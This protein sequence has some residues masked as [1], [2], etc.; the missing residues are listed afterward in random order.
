MIIKRIVDIGIDI[1]DPINVFADPQGLLR[2][3]SAQYVGHCYFGCFVVSVDRII[4]HGDCI[5]NKCD[6]PTF[7]TILARIEITAQIYTKG[8]VIVG[9]RMVKALD[10]NSYLCEMD[11]ASI[12]LVST[13]P[14]P[15]SIVS[16]MVMQSSYNNN[17]TKIS[18]MCIPFTS[19][20]EYISYRNGKSAPIHAATLA[21]LRQC[22]Q[23]AEEAH[24]ANPALWDQFTAALVPFKTPP[25]VQ[26]GTK[27]ASLAKDPPKEGTIISINPYVSDICQITNDTPDN[28]VI[29]TISFDAIFDALV[30]EYCDYLRVVREMVHSYASVDQDM[31]LR[32]L[33]KAKK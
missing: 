14:I 29:A 4:K 30:G 24:A 20:T 22:E 28:N 16:M 9:G 2:V 13:I 18:M 12:A 10:N 11:N 5:I 3:I 31:I 25:I 6:S 33:D 1:H 21:R 32:M 23:A 7:G 15:M 17:A 19:P 27:L 8:E 26:G